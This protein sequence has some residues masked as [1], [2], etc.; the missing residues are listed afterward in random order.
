[1]EARENVFAVVAPPFGRVAAVAPTFAVAHLFR[2]LDLRDLIRWNTLK[3]SISQK[4]FFIKI[5]FFSGCSRA[6]RGRRRQYAI[7]MFIFSRLFQHCF[8][9]RRTP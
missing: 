5:I 8:N 4:S 9:S 6:P 2:P 3:K 1:M 7:A